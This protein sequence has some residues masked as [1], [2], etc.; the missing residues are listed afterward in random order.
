MSEDAPWWRIGIAP[1]ASRYVP[2]GKPFNG[3]NYTRLVV[4]FD[5]Q[6]ASYHAHQM[7]WIDEQ[8]SALAGR[9][10]VIIVFVHGWKHN[11][12]PR[13]PNL[14][15]IDKVLKQTADAEAAVGL[16][17]PVIGIF[18]G[19]RSLSVWRSSRPA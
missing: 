11:A 8:L 14:L 6:G 10:P 19:W 1:D 7:E 17:R 9:Q 4:E 15:A 2:H 12:R 16:N 13:D 5:D 3:G 18:V